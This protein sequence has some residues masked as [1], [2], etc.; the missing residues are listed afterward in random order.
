MS[1]DEIPFRDAGKIAGLAY[2]TIK[3]LRYQGN[4]PWPVYERMLEGRR[5]PKLYCR[6]SDIEAW[7]DKTTIKVPAG[8]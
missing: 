5:K 7:K 1:N 4:L 8:A 6:V 3:R 2:N